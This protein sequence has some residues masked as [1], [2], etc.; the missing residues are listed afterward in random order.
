MSLTINNQN[1][2][3]TVKELKPGTT[4]QQAEA[5]LK[6]AKDGMDTIGFTANGKD[7]LAIGKGLKN[8]SDKQVMLDGKEGKV[9]FFENESNTAAEG[10]LKG[11]KS[12]AGIITTAASTVIGAGLGTAGSFLFSLGS[13]FAGGGAAAMA[14]A[15]IIACAI[16]AGGIGAGAAAGIGAIHATVTKGNP[17]VVNQ[18]TK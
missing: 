2:N 16:I 7:Y 13:A 15:P 14:G 3:V 17:T 5:I 6:N 9:V 18:L 8:P 10:A 12:T 4:L 11:I 1:L